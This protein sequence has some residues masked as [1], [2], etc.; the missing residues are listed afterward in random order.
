MQPGDY[1]NLVSNVNSVLH[2]TI[3]FQTLPSDN[4]YFGAGADITSASTY[5]NALVATGNSVV[6][7]SILLTNDDGTND[8]KADVVYTD[9]SDNILGYYAYKMVVPADAT[10]ELLENPKYL[11]QNHKIRVLANQADRLEVV[12]AGKKLAQGM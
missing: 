12:V 4:T 1:I 7:E 2:A 5:T 8:V 6:L 3:T 10:I 11:T 9:G